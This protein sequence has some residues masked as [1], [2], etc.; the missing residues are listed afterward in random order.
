MKRHNRHVISKQLSYFKPKNSY[1][2]RNMAHEIAFGLR[3]DSK[4]ISPKFFYDQKGS[5]LFERICRLPEYYIARTENQLLLDIKDELPKFLDGH[6][7]LVELGSGSSTKTRHILDVLSRSQPSPEY[8][9]IDISE[10]LETSMSALVKE[11]PGL[12]VTGIMDT[13]ENGLHLVAD[14]NTTNLIAF[15]GSSLG[16]FPLADR[17]PFL[18]TVRNS[19]NKNDLF[20]LGLD[21]VKDRAVLENAYDDSQGVTAQFNLNILERIN[22]DLD[23]DFDLDGFS[24]HSLYN[25]SE[26][27]IEMYLRSLR[28]QHVV[29]PKANLELTFEEDELVHTENSHKFSIP[30]I[31]SMMTD[32]GFYIVKL[33]QD[34]ETKFALVLAGKDC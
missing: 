31:D 30:G 21:L 33:W 16:N 13:Y 29:I 2:E 7:C 9:P 32:A 15:L 23:A 19:M 4:F 3:Q 11:Y 22:N 6:F 28:R 14:R 8:V 12:C 34:A 26:Q 18:R 20:L 17:L 24:H 25:E 27:R 1:R 5:E 10:F